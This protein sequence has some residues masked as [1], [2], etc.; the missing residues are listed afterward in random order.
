MGTLERTGNTFNTPEENLAY[1]LVKYGA[2][3]TNRPEKYAKGH[4]I[5]AQIDLEA[6]LEDNPRLLAPLIVLLTQHPIFLKKF[7]EIPQDILETVKALRKGDLNGPD[8][9]Y[10]NF[11]KLVKLCNIRND[12]RVKATTERKIRK[13]W[14]L[15]PDVIE[16]IEAQVKKGKFKTG[17][18]LIETL[19][20]N[21]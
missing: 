15:A 16:K 7:I 3:V 2:M 9:R 18:E 14:R 17:T 10:E 11:K 19:V 5:P 13:E 21:F 4:V 8:C 12:G 6:A 1:L 20:R